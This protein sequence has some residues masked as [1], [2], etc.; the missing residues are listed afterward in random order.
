[1]RQVNVTVLKSWLGHATQTTI[2]PRLEQEIKDAT[3][4]AFMS[5]NHSKRVQAHGEPCALT[6]HTSTSTRAQAHKHTGNNNSRVQT[7]LEL[8]TNGAGAVH[9]RRWSCVQTAL[10]LCTNGAGAVYKRRWSCVQ[11]ALELVRRLY[12]A[13]VAIRSPVCLNP[14][15]ELHRPQSSSGSGPLSSNRPPH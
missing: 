5:D 3:H 12:T 13:V 15:Y 9:K 7:A 14:A 11:T 4:Q 2:K 1:M 8:C 10:E 6:Q